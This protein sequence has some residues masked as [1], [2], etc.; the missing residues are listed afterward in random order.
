MD[1]VRAWY[2]FINIDDDLVTVD[3]PTDEN[4]L[5]EIQVAQAES[6]DEECS[7]S[8]FERICI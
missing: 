2:V 3:S 7:H 5:R 6:D 4:I 1:I 8:K